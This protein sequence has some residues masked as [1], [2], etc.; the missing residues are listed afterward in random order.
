MRLDL[1]GQV[2]NAAEVFS[3]AM[4]YLQA[5]PATEEITNERDEAR[6]LYE[7]AGHLGEDV[8]GVGLPGDAPLARPRTAVC[9]GGHLR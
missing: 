1:E 5:A 3:A 7:S 9:S 6:R 8:Q 2:E 4:M